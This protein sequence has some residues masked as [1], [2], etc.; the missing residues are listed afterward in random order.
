MVSFRPVG[1]QLVLGRRL[2]RR[3]RGAAADLDLGVR[4]G[5]QVQD[6]RVRLL[7]AWVDVT[8]D[9]AVAVTQ[10]QQRD[11]PRLAGASAGG[12]QEQDGG[13][14]GQREAAAAAAVWLALERRDDPA[15]R[16]HAQ[17]SAAQMLDEPAEAGQ[18]SVSA[19]AVTV[20]GCSLAAPGPRV[21][22]GDTGEGR[23][24]VSSRTR[25]IRELQECGS[26][27][28]RAERCR[29]DWQGIAGHLALTWAKSG[30][31][32]GLKVFERSAATDRRA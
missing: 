30:L 3:R 32:G 9:Q 22:A 25:R 18:D 15:D 5:P 16:E 26:A 11:R 14:A 27:R 23:A 7:E 31:T 4:L 17:P 2:R 8:D 24:Q 20:A 1:C 10:V 13:A 12:R 19:H 28:R 6:P 29:C 21:M